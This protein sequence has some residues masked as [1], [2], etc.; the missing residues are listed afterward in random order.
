MRA[1]TGIQRK[2]N[3]PFPHPHP[4]PTTK[5]KVSN[6]PVDLNQISTT[7]P[8]YGPGNSRFGAVSS[9]QTLWN[10]LPGYFDGFRS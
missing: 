1:D 5:P 3:T 2:S 10:T 4:T 9:S 7:S 6:L 8:N